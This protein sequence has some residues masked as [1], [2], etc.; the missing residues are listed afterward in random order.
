LPQNSDIP[1]HTW[2][3]VEGGDF[4]DDPQERLGPFSLKGDRPQ[5]IL[6]ASGN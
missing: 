5:N 2:K 4:L 1:G 6:G 3:V